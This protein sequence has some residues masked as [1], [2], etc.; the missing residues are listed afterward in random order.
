MLF[1]SSPRRILGCSNGVRTL[2]YDLH[3]TNT[4]KIDKINYY[5]F[6]RGE[7]VYQR[8]TFCRWAPPSVATGHCT[9]AL[10]SGSISRYF[11]GTRTES[12]LPLRIAS[13]N[14][15]VFV[16]CVPRK[17]THPVRR[18]LY[19]GAITLPRRG[20]RARTSVRPWRRP[21]AGKQCGIYRS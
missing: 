5:I 21:G 12:L 15:I 13:G 11:A 1:L 18:V 3:Y 4:S 19:G 6:S 17:K 10:M 20:M 2:H 14:R 16:N 8:T 9:R 7:N